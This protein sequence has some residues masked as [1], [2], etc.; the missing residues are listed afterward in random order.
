MNEPVKPKRT[1]RIR[2]IAAG[3]TV[4][5]AACSSEATST[6]APENTASIT[7]NLAATATPA[8]SAITTSTPTTEQTT[9]APVQV[10]PAEGASA[11]GVPPGGPGIMGQVTEVNGT[12]ITVQDQRQQSTTQISLTDSTQIFKQTAIP[13][14]NAPVGETVSAFGTQDGDVFTASRAQLGA[15]SGQVVGPGGYGNQQGSQPPQAGGPQDGQP[16]DGR[17]QVGNR[18]QRL[19][20]TIEQATVD[21]LTIKTSDGATVQLHLGENGQ[22]LQHVAGTAADIII[23]AQVRVMGEQGDA[24]ITASRIDVMAGQT[25]QP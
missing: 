20:G 15:T 23:G 5:L 19:V 16:Q 7:V 12:T 6:A 2:L 9:P 4:I 13:L 22:L 10:A 1:I 3:L 24:G 11:N 21:S 8:E 18:G 17:P 14:A 25:P